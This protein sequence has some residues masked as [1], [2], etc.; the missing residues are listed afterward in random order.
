MNRGGAAEIAACCCLG[1][2]GSPGKR[3]GGG[4]E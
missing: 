3:N 4:D 2:L 1:V